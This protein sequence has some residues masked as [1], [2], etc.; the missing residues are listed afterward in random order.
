M[1]VM[2]L[3]VCCVPEE[4]ISFRSVQDLCTTTRCARDANNLWGCEVFSLIWSTLIERNSR[5]FRGQVSHSTILWE[6]IVFRASLQ[7]RIFGPS[8]EC[9]VD[10]VKDG[11][12][13]M[14]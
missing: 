11:T 13:D 2:E 7:A 9:L 1:R 8:K 12:A 14:F 5:I 4:W 3:L 10:L 6:R